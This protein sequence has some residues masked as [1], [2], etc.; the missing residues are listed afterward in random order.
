MQYHRIESET[1]AIHWDEPSY[2]WTPLCACW[3][4]LAFC[5]I[6]KP[7]TEKTKI[8]IPITAQI[9]SVSNILS[10]SLQSPS[11]DDRT[12]MASP[13]PCQ[14]SWLKRPTAHIQSVSINT[15]KVTESW[16]RGTSWPKSFGSLFER[17][18][19]WTGECKFRENPTQFKIFNISTNIFYNFSPA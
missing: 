1:R 10:P 7:P 16:G 19:T 5:Q 12:A 13:P 2:P 17:H 4:P 18:L 11:I 8:S 15:G 6:S 14:R 9:N 3:P